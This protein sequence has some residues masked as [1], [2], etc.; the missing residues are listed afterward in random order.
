MIPCEVFPSRT[1]TTEQLKALGNALQKFFELSAPFQGATFGDR[2]SDAV[3]DLLA[4]EL[5]SPCAL[6]QHWVGRTR[7]AQVIRNRDDLSPVEAA[8][9]IGE[10]VDKARTVAF[11]INC[12][13]DEWLA[14]IRACL[15]DVIDES[16]VTNV[17]ISGHPW[18]E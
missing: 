4:G 3:S 9:Y 2:E 1:A 10:V 18:Q 16:L 17:L 7:S 14:R 11:I 15:A 5:P 12:E 8:S 13:D 6:R